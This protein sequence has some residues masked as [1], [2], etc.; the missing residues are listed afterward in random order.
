MFRHQAEHVP[1]TLAKA[2][3]AEETKHAIDVLEQLRMI[4]RVT[5]GVLVDARQAK[6]H[7]ATLKAVDRIQRQIELQ[8]KLLGELSDAPTINI[9]V[10]PQWIEVRAVLLDALAPYPEARIAAAGCLVALGH[11]VG[12]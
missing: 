1:Q 11:E 4:N 9:N 7:D 2:R 6:D 5:A 8:A 10:N 3:E 12:S